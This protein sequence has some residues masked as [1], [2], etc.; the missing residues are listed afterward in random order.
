MGN[1]LEVLA[2]IVPRPIKGLYHDSMRIETC[3]CI[4]LHWRNLRITMSAGQFRAFARTTSR[5]LRKW[6]R[7]GQPIQQGDVI[8]MHSSVKEQTLNG[9]VVAAEVNGRGDG[10]PNHIHVHYKDMRLEMLEEEFLQLT[11]C[12]AGAAARLRER[13]AD[14]E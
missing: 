13:R 12:L 4:H 10:E 7:L 3:E 6:I 14:G 8:L 11:D 2:R 1:V 9:D 5:A